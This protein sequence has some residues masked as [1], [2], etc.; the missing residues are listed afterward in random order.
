M[1][2]TSAAALGTACAVLLGTGTRS[3]VSFLDPGAL[4]P[5]AAIIRRD[6]GSAAVPA[7]RTGYDGQQFYAIARFFP[8]LSRAAHYLD[9]P[10]YRLLRIGAPA[11]ASVAG[12]GTGL[13]VALLVLNVLG[14]G[15]AVGALADL[16]RRHGRPAWIGYAAVPALLEGLTVSTPEPLAVGLAMTALCAADRGRHGR[17]VVLLVASALVRESG[18]VV[19]VAAVAGLV[20]SRPRPRWTVAALY[21][22]PAL[23]VVAWS[24]ALGWIVGGS[25]LVTQR[26]APLGLLGASGP[27]IALG[28]GALLLAA[29]GAWA[30]RD[31]AVLWP[32]AAIFGAWI[33]VFTADTSDWLALPRAAAPALVLGVSAAAALIA[34]LVRS[35]VTAAPSA[36]QPS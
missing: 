4:G 19:A 3:A 34:R 2:L 13:V 26:V 33:L 16:A 32:V 20:L 27:S 18:A 10:R 7:G 21:L 8:H 15:L 31:V 11:L 30:W 23:V 25:T 6:F 5:S 35:N 14:V 1:G 29:V 24:E 12:R 22:V 36:L 17:A 28:L 9:A